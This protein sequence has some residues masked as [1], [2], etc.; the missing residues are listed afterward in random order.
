MTER[1]TDAELDGELENHRECSFRMCLERPDHCVWHGHES[2]GWPCVSHRAIAELRALR[3]QAAAHICE[4]GAIA[5]LKD[6]EIAK[7]RAEVDELKER[8]DHAFDFPNHNALA[9]VKG[10]TP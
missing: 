2:E 5:A 9:S 10:M 3:E 6:E 7:L 1:L 8:L 4:G